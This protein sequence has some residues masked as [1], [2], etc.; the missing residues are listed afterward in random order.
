[1]ACTTP[2]TPGAPPAIPPP[3]KDTCNAAQYAGLIGKPAT[4]SAVPPASRQVRHIRPDSVVTMDFSETRL[5][6][7][8]NAAGVITGLRCF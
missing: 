1:M 4:D 5:N 2:P 8:I 7:D 6:I 3:D